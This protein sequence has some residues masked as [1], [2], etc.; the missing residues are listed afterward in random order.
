MILFWCVIRWIGSCA[1][2]VKRIW[3]GKCFTDVACIRWEKKAIMLIHSSKDERV[4]EKQ[5]LGSVHGGVAIVQRAKHGNAFIVSLKNFDHLVS[6]NFFL[7]SL[8]NIKFLSLHIDYLRITVVIH[9]L[10]I[11]VSTLITFLSLPE[12]NSAMKNIK[13][14]NF[15]A[16][17]YSRWFHFF[18]FSIYDFYMTCSCIILILWY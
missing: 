6:Y 4:K 11:L 16:K 13:R 8:S 1:R 9:E 17:F 10:Y 18:Y 15:L 7:F 3:K 2:F 5:Q 12:L 14:H